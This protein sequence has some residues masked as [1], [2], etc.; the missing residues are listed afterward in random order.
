MDRNSPYNKPSKRVRT[1]ESV[2]QDK[3]EPRIAGIQ[4]ESLFEIAKLRGSL[5]TGQ[6]LK[7]KDRLSAGKA[8]IEKVLEVLGFDYK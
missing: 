3:V 6:T 4:L 7:D 1:S 2:S 8:V 5:R